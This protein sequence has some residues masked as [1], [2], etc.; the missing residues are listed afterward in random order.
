M[1]DVGKCVRDVQWRC[2]TIHSQKCNQDLTRQKIEEYQTKTFEF[3]S[4]NHLYPEVGG[5]RFIL[6]QIRL[7]EV[8]LF[9]VIWFSFLNKKEKTHGIMYFKRYHL[10]TK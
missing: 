7:I 9:L 10:K 5:N 6:F 4:E 2:E 3:V 1:R 8:H